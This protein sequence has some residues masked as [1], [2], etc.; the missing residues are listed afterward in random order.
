MAELG[1][2]DVQLVTA[3]ESVILTQDNAGDATTVTEDSGVED[4]VNDNADPF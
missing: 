3:E 1:N 4:P 2:G